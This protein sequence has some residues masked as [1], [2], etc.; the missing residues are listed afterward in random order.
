[1]SHGNDIV[2]FGIPT[3]EY[4]H[5]YY[6]GVA[7]INIAKDGVNGFELKPQHDARYRFVSADQIG[8]TYTRTRI[9]SEPASRGISQSPWGQT[10]DSVVRMQQHTFE[11]INGLEKEGCLPHGLHYRSLEMQLRKDWF[12]LAQKTNRKYESYGV[13]VNVATEL[14]ANGVGGTLH[15]QTEPELVGL[16]FEILP[17]EQLRQTAV[18]ST[19]HS[20][21]Q[22]PSLSRL[23]DDL[24]N[25]LH[26]LNSLHQTRA[27]TAAEFATVKAEF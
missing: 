1:M 19:T 9:P 13:H 7:N 4:N 12:K 23:R 15:R 27:L 21:A 2:N 24:T 17:M 5:G 20:S 18:T 25:Q 16:H 8:W 22:T 3:T 26:A 10:H 6:G 11:A 14:Q